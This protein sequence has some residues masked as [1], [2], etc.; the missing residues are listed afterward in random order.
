MVDAVRNDLKPH[1]RLEVWKRSLEVVKRTY[2]MTTLWPQEERYGL[3]SQARRAAVS[4][5]ANIAEGAGRQTRKEFINF[6]HIAQ[7]SLSELDTHFEIAG[8]LGYR[9]DSGAARSTTEVSKMLTGLIRSL[10]S[11]RNGFAAPSVLKSVSLLA[12]YCLLGFQAC[13]G[14]TDSYGMDEEEKKAIMQSVAESGVGRRESAV[15]SR[16]ARE[17]G[18]RRGGEPG[19]RGRGEG[20]RSDE[21]GSRDLDRAFGMGSDREEMMARATPSVTLQAAGLPLRMALE[22]LGLQ[23]EW[24]VKWDEGVDPE[25][26]VSADLTEIPFHVAV[27]GLV[28]QA[29]YTAEFDFT[30]HTALVRR[31]IERVFYLP[32]VWARR[33]AALP[34]SNGGGVTVRYA[35]DPGTALQNSIRS[36][37]SPEGKVM[38]DPISGT[39][40]V[41]DEHQNI[42]ALD[43]YFR[44]IEAESREPWLVEVAILLASPGKDG[45]SW[46]SVAERIG[47]DRILPGGPVAL[48]GKLKG[49]DTDPAAVFLA[50][51][52]P[53]KARLVSRPRV[54]ALNGWTVHMAVESSPG[55]QA[56]GWEL[57]VTPHRDYSNTGRVIVEMAG[58]VA[59][60]LNHSFSTTSTAE[61]GQ[62]L[63]VSTGAGSTTEKGWFGDT[64]RTEQAVFIVRVLRTGQSEQ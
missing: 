34:G 52:A 20:E 45:V 48:E 28:S 22:R 25:R 18:A 51:L 63:I 29:G 56:G 59:D 6:L 50:G 41:R 24:S 27:D 58:G 14:K 40:I 13:A 10:K 53:E 23:A 12:A 47:L 8:V 44:Q 57:Y 49:E 32:E 31:Y 33:P 43:R 11:A 35:E 15:G 4:V 60:R 54:V 3:S 36:F 64:E 37:L 30:A 55:S 2:E 26:A 5:A 21:R 19:S 42:R 16:E 1:K 61:I 62:P 38:V 7:A 17:Q 46:E 9:V 39:A